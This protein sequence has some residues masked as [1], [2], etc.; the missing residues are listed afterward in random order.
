MP[1]QFDPLYTD[2]NTGE[3]AATS[4][5]NALGGIFGGGDPMDIAKAK[6]LGGSY[7]RD[8]A[9]AALD[10]DVL[11]AR[12]PEALSLLSDPNLFSQD[13][14]FDSSKL[15]DVF[16]LALRNERSP[17]E[18]IN[19]LTAMRGNDEY[20]RR[21]LIAAGKMP[22]V[23]T[24]LSMD[25]SNA[26]SARDAG[27]D[28]SRALAVQGLSNS[29]AMERLKATP[30]TTA[31]LEAK[32]LESQFSPEELGQ[33]FITDRVGDITPRNV[34][35]P[36]VDGKDPVRTTA[37]G[38]MYYDETGV[39]KPLPFGSS[40]FTAQTSGEGPEEALGLTPSVTT[41]LQKQS[42][43]LD[44]I[45]NT[46]D[47]I[48]GLAEADP[49]NFGTVG[50]A[51]ST[52]QDLAAQ[53]NALGQ[54][55]EDE[56]GAAVSKIIERENNVDTSYFD[57]ALPALELMFNTLAYQYAVA[58]AG[59]DRISDS[60]F[61]VARQAVGDPSSFM[62]SAEKTL[63][64]MNTL[65]TMVQQKKNSYSNALK[66]GLNT[67]PAI[68]TDTPEVVDDIGLEDLSDEQLIELMRG[69]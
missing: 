28:K 21:G 40:I 24:A 29:G 51:K 16:S 35:L 52:V 10:E 37:V 31:Q 39:L 66:N 22:D 32:T 38:N 69:G 48:T 4:I 58:I 27:E 44:D 46:I 65:K 56:S 6:A 8:T 64:K 68:P 36:G 19:P 62:G 41:T 54:L 34:I 45:T 53:G 33:V 26:I 20:K 11:A 2:S 13:G 23:N 9:A 47:Y 15:G 50:M 63:A 5:A 30:L 42:L 49:T 67:A 7:R 59:N 57:P 61:L 43:A 25:E 55:L 12:Q 14:S 17:G 60:D 1:R 3:K 18:I